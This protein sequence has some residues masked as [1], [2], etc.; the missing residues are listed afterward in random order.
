VST[1][2][3][4]SELKFWAAGERPLQTLAA[5]ATLGPAELGPPR[6]VDELDHYVDT[7]DL[8]LGAVRWACRIRERD[9]RTILSLKGPAEHGA[10]EAVHRRPELEG[11]AGPRLDPATWPPSAARDLLVDLSGGA[12]LLERFTLAQH[13]TERTV[14]WAGAPVGLLSLD[15]SRVRHFGVELGLL[16]V[17]E[18]EFG[19]DTNPSGLDPAPLAAALAAIPG[20][21]H[22]PL[23]KLERALALLPAAS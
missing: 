6:P 4:E 16:R 1:G 3:I 5:A 2:R 13:R 17:G 11:V 10:G 15:R 12:P 21:E 19:R 7:A 9:G 20:L 23:T 18:R 22:D 14:T 8:R